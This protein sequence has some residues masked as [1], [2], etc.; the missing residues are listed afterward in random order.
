MRYTLK[1]NGTFN[2]EDTR[3]FE[4]YLQGFLSRNYLGFVDRDM[5][6]VCYVDEETGSK[7]ITDKIPTHSLIYIDVPDR[8]NAFNEL[9]EII[10]EIGVP[11]GSVL[12]NEEVTIPVGTLSQI[13][14]NYTFDTAKNIKKKVDKLEDKLECDYLDELCV[15]S[16][17]Y[18]FGKEVRYFLYV[19]DVDISLPIIEAFLENQKE[20]TNM[21]IKTSRS[22][23]GIAHRYFSVLRRRYKVENIKL[24]ESVKDIYQGAS[25]ED[26]DALLKEYPNIPGSL[27]DLLKIIDG[28][29]DT[30]HEKG[31]VNLPVFT[32]VEAEIPL[33]LL[34]AKQM[35]INKE[36]AK[37]PIIN[38]IANMGVEFDKFISNDLENIHVLPLAYSEPEYD[39]C[40]LY[41]D[42]HPSNEGDYG[43]I[44]VYS[45]DDN[46]YCTASKSLDEFLL[47]MLNNDFY[48]MFQKITKNEKFDVDDS[49][50]EYDDLEEAAESIFWEFAKT[51]YKDIKEFNKDLKKYMKSMEEAITIAELKEIVLE[52]REI[53]IAYE[54]WIE[55]VSQLKENE[56]L[57]LEDGET[58]LEE[59]K[60][61]GLWQVTI[62]ARLKS[63]AKKGFALGELMMKAHNQMA[64]KELFDYVHFEGFD[65]LGQETEVKGLVERAEG[66]PVFEVNL[67]S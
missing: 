51:T 46:S 5:T 65:Y 35:I 27:I 30:N 41:I 19:V 44:I 2:L 67:G 52:E 38:R 64:N 6:K 48:D 13:E 24:W 57:E 62:L 39:S 10:D 53:I 22:G 58:L 18:I 12:Q 3:N 32:T 42:F 61:D 15:V 37:K 26:I 28:T 16:H 36:L 43:Q 40:E 23:Y 45:Q 54:A 50:E 25:E 33:N 34:S 4:A 20:I 55:E 14:V 66:L 29:W 8:E 60:E 21:D 47:D 7:N 11:L 63:E 1:L 49:E 59:E 17:S 56:V 9:L 31:L